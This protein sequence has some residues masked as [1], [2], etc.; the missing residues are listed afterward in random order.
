VRLAKV[1]ILHP[2]G[3]RRPSAGDICHRLVRSKSVLPWRGEKQPS[4]WR[5]A[6][7]F[8]AR[9]VRAGGADGRTL[10]R[11]QVRQDAVREAPREHRLT[12]ALAAP[13]VSQV[14][15]QHLKPDVHFRLVHDRHVHYEA[16]RMIEASFQEPPDDFRIVSHALDRVVVEHR[17]ASDLERAPSCGS[18]ELGVAAVSP[19]TDHVAGSK[20]LGRSDPPRPPSAAAGR[21]ARAER[22][23]R[24]G[25]L[26]AGSIYRA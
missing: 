4:V 15:E 11:D 18:A 26:Q 7:D 21:R 14:L 19:W 8:A 10:G 5:R 25:R 13:A 2:I 24:E 20:E 3:P 9:Q 17:K 6:D 12:V 1:T 23:R 16:S 22:L